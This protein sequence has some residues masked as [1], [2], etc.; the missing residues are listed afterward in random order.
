MSLSELRRDF[1]Q[2]RIAKA[3]FIEAMYRHHGLLHEYSELLK[4]T[5]V[6]A[7]EI[8]EGRVVMT[9]RE[10][11]L[12]LAIAAGDRRPAPLEM[13]NFGTYEREFLEA[14]LALMDEDADV[15]DVGANIGWYALT[16]SRRRPACRIF[17]FEPIPRTFRDLEENIRINGAANV[18][19]MPFGLSEREE[20]KT[21]YFYPEGAANASAANVSG[22]KDARE[23]RCRV[24][25][26][27]DFV[28]E[29][30]LRPG[31]IKCDVEGAELFVLR[32]GQDAVSRHKPVI[33]CEML[34]KWTAPFGYHPNDIIALLGGLGYRCYLLEGRD[35]AE[36][37]VVDES[38]VDTNFFFL[39]P[40]AHAA[41][42]K[43][44]AARAG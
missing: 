24:R 9:I 33:F 36:C 8:T 14:S 23:L 27:D 38:T 3:D 7:I 25:R 41:K 40:A 32:G 20:E 26:L 2:G 11:G 5:E 4:D 10:T 35:L 21:F 30:G 13:L 1:A 16:L 37:P 18:R 42:L 43:A 28:R 12:R 29:E 15:L 39:H 44:F 31:F 6:S 17:S 19:P 34:R 22:R